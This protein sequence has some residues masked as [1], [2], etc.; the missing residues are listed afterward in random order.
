MTS[1][2][3]SLFGLLCLGCFE[4]SYPNCHVACDDGSC[5]AGLTCDRGLCRQPDAVSCA[6]AIGWFSRDCS[7]VLIA[8]NAVVTNGH[9]LDF[10]PTLRQDDAFVITGGDG[11]RYTFKVDRVT[12]FG[13]QRRT[14]DIVVEPFEPT[15]QPVPDGTGVN[16]VALLHLASPVPPDLAAPAVIADAPPELG[17]KV[18]LYGLGCESQP[19]HPAGGGPVQSFTYVLGSDADVCAYDSGG[20]IVVGDDARGPVWAL[21]MGLYASTPGIVANV[22][23]FK[24]L[25]MSFLRRW[26]G[27]AQLEIGFDRPGPSIAEFSTPTPQPGDCAQ[28]CIANPDCRAFTNQGTHCSLKSGSVGWIPD[29]TATSAVR[30]L[31]EGGIIRAGASYRD[32][33]LSN[34]RVCFEECAGDASCAAWTLDRGSGRCSL[35]HARPEPLLDGRYDSGIK[36][37]FSP[38][39]LQGR[40]LRDFDVVDAEACR[41]SCAA[42]ARCRGFTVGSVP[43]HCWHMLTVRSREPSP[44]LSFVSAI[45]GGIG[46]DRN[47]GTILRDYDM[48]SV[49]AAEG[50]QADCA[51]DPA[52]RAWAYAGGTYSSLPH[53]W[54]KSDLQTEPW[55]G[56]AT[57][58][59]GAEFTEP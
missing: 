49:F 34:G 54:L 5:P 14:D 6:P 31:F 21:N 15:N 58:V 17:E 1:M 47:G 51:A 25:I 8:P 30:P 20:P 10:T 22:T 44:D 56:N 2:R 35:M 11:A 50:C 16:D 32:F 41:Q 39:V 46:G 45:R 53:C 29:P 3:A 4:P 43:L 33:D 55:A 37:D 23:Y 12:F 36:V 19:P 57:G 27:N 9:C 40:P 52:C 38:G 28:A 42:D 18:T 24:T 59:K 13:A 7:A 48:S 26:A